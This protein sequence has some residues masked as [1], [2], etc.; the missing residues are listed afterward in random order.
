MI[1]PQIIVIGGPN[2]AG[3]STI[4]SALLPEAV[5]YINADEIAKQLGDF[6]GNREIEAGRQLLL[7]WKRLGRDQADFAIETTLASR[8]LAPK[9]RG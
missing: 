5:P 2:G 4:A 3:K 1:S 6:E 9:I 8:S 7:E